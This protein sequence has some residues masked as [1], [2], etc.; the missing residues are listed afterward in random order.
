[1]KILHI[2]LPAEIASDL[3]RRAQ[4][5]GLSPQQLLQQVIQGL[6]AP[7]A[8]TRNK[9]HS[10]AWNHLS[11]EPEKVPDDPLEREARDLEVTRRLAGLAGRGSRPGQRG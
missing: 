2:L 9:Y 4:G 10:A 6:T 5:C 11:N 1:M 8:R 3:E 7:V